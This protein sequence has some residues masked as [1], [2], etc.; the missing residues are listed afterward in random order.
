MWLTK[1][2]V[3]IVEKDTQ[4]FSKLIEAVPKLE[5]TEEMSEAVY[6]I[7]EASELL[8]TLQDATSASMKQIKKNLIF[9]KST[10]APRASQLD[11]KS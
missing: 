10:E 2:K 7:R 8:Y 5:S 9:L 6:L 1:L 4:T 3:A 11:I